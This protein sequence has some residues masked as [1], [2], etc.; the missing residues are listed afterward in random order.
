ME[1]FT[2]DFADVTPATA[3]VDHEWDLTGAEFKITADVDNKVMA[4]IDEKI[5]KNASPAPADLASAAVYYNDN[6][7]DP[8]AGAGLDR[9]SQRRRAHQVLEPEHGSQNPPE[10][11]GLQRRHRRRP[12]LRRKPPWPPRPPNGEYVKMDEEL[13]AEAK[14][15]GNI[16][17]FSTQRRL[18]RQAVQVLSEA[19]HLSRSSNHIL[20]RRDASAALSMTA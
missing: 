3:N 13:L 8:E 2:I 12:R 18:Q 17:W 15:M 16:A 10:N 7:K 14:K 20:A 5:T 1:T 9:E 4:Q 11:E 6:N 19:K